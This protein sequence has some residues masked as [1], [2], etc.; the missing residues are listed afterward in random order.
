MRALWLLLA[1]GCADEVVDPCAPAGDAPR[2]IADVVARVDALGGDVQIGC[3]V[4]SLPR[5]LPLEA[6]AETA[7]AQPAVDAASPRLLSWVE[8]LTMTFA[9]GGAG[10]SLLELGEDLPDGRTIKAEIAFPA[11]APYDEAA[12]YVAV[13]HAVAGFATRCGVCHADESEVEPGVFASAPL[14]PG[15]HLIVPLD[16]VA[17]EARA[18]AGEDARCVMLRAMFDHGEVVHAPLPE[19]W[20]TLYRP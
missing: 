8:G 3:F 15:E 7:S 16:D 14:R 9:T 13:H 2:S 4:S 19:A 12:P 5:P 10:A 20:G 6:S 17:A 18:C 11:A 1:V